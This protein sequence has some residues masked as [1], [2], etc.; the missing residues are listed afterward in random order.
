MIPIWNE[1]LTD[2]INEQASYV[3]S[4]EE[5]EFLLTNRLKRAVVM[6]IKNVPFERSTQIHISAVL[7]LQ[8]RA[9][10]LLN[11]G[12]IKNLSLLGESHIIHYTHDAIRTYVKDFN[13]KVQLVKI[14]QADDSHEFLISDVPFQDAIQLDPH[15]F[16]P[17]SGEG[18][19]VVL[20][21]SDDIDFRQKL[22]SCH[23]EK[24][25]QLSNLQRSISSELKEL[26]ILGVYIHHDSNGNLHG[27]MAYKDVELK[28]VSYS[29]STSHEFVRNFISQM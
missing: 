19:Y 13:E 3:S 16:I 4:Y 28:Y 27:S 23:V 1:W 8:N 14:D 25:M 22:I 11:K 20:C 5:A 15:E 9:F 2:E 17:A 10:Y 24:V 26:E 21:K 12:E 18:I 29:Q 7:P 6:C